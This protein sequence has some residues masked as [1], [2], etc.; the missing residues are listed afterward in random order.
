MGNTSSEEVN[1]KYTVIEEL[2]AISMTIDKNKL[3]LIDE[4]CKSKIKLLYSGFYNPKHTHVKLSEMN[5]DFPLIRKK[6]YKIITLY[7]KYNNTNI[8]PNE[9][10]KNTVNCIKHTLP[11]IDM[12]DMDELN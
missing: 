12:V 2:K 7:N 4:G 5:E 1:A 8:E 10:V 3:H 9:Y 11:I 6:I